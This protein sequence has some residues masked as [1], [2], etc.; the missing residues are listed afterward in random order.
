MEWTP[1]CSDKIVGA[2]VPTFEVPGAAV[3]I[4]QDDH[5]VYI[6]GFGVR[7]LGAK[8]EVTPDTVFAI[9]SCTKAF[10]ATGIALLVAEKKMN[11]DDPV[12]KHLDFF[13]LREPSADH[14][15]TIRDLVCHRT[16]MPRHDW[17]RVAN[18]DVE[19]E[20]RAYGRAKPSTSFRSTWEYANVPL[21]AAGF[22]IGRVE[23][24]DWQTV[25]AQ[26]PVRA[27]ENG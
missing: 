5:I 11:W 12:G 17:L 13:R 16:G 19:K 26:T 2:A 23:G 9:A 1:P 15:V 24:S 22:A 6:K 25:T 10:T 7:K 18:L 27:A 14:E 4:V 3:A 20:I 8:E 21:N